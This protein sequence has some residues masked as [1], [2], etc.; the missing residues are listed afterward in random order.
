M[1]VHIIHRP[2]TNNTCL[3]LANIYF[4]TFFPLSY[5]LLSVTW[6]LWPKR[7]KYLLYLLTSHNEKGQFSSLFPSPTSSAP[8]PP[9]HIYISYIYYPYIIKTCFWLNQDSVYTLIELCNFSNSYSTKCA[10]ITFTFLAQ[11]FTFP[12]VNVLILFA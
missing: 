1:K 5:K 7:I 9:W 11:L 12:W 2:C 4:T 6:G 3:P 8:C 10:V